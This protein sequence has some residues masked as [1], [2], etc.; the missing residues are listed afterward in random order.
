MSEC[1]ESN[2]LCREWSAIAGTF[3]KM[4]VGLADMRQDPDYLNAYNAY[5]G[6]QMTCPVCSSRRHALAEAVKDNPVKPFLSME[7]L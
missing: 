4:G 7:D 3:L 1:E 2:R 5:F 6:H